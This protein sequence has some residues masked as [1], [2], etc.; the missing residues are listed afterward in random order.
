MGEKNITIYD[1]AKKAG[2]SASMVSRVISGKGFVSEANRIRIQQLLKEYN[3]KPNAVARGLQKQRS[4]MIGFLLPHIANQY[5]S[6]VYYEFERRASE[7]GFLTVLFNGKNDWGTELRL[8]QIMEESRVE[9]IVIMGGNADAIDIPEEYYQEILRIN[10]R[11]P[12]VI[13]GEQASRFGCVGIHPNSKS[14]GELIKHLAFLGFESAGIFGGGNSRYPSLLKKHTFIET[15]RQYHIQIKKE[16]ILGNSYDAA[17]GSE[18]MK[19][20]LKEKDL[21][22]AVCC[23]NDHVAAGAITVAIAAGLRVP[24]DIAFTG[25]DGVEVSSIFHPSITTMR[26]DYEQYGNEI[27]CAVQRLIQGERCPEMT[28]IDSRMIVGES[29]V[30][31]DHS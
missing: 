12:C 20:L 25:Y 13:C 14:A 18:A 8:L 24:E 17:D 29:T 16:W 23:M 9:A 30:K 4:K 5:F 11:I 2:V 28:F 26:Y 22:R 27:F 7:Q 1:I 3:F 19:E 31:V 10:Q 6:S 21:P 15:A